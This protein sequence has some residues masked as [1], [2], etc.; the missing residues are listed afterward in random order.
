LVRRLRT[1]H[2]AEVPDFD[3]DLTVHHA[4][5]PRG[6]APTLLLVH[7]LT[8]SGRG[9]VEAV[10]H[11]E[12]R[13]AI[14][15]YDQRGHGE[16][17]RFTADELDAAPG[18]LLVDDVLHLLERLDRPVVVGHS[19]GGAVALAAAVRRPELVQALVLE[20]PA[21]RGPEEPQRTGR[22]QEFLAG[23]QESVAAPDEATLYELRKRQHPH[24]PESELLVTGIAERQTD[25]AFLER[26]SYKPATPWTELYAE[27]R[28][29][30][31]VVTGDDADEI[32]VSDEV[33]RGMAGLGNPRVEVVR[34]AGAGHCVRRDRPD[35][36]YAA[37]D[38][39]LAEQLAGR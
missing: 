1:G 34:I 13:W 28:V 15:S 9:W 18:D 14:V 29:P 20:D 19:L 25:T 32:L 4:G 12:D 31:L 27:V 22:G 21:P 30:T 24:W 5:R 16:S 6:K 26:G 10:S 38:G 33:E 7:G 35:A 3:T 17:P 23:I 36:F 39:W 2:H 11:W 37:V 8:D